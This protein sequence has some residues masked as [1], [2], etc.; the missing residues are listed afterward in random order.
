MRKEM[1]FILKWIWLVPLL[2]WIILTL[3]NPVVAIT[4]PEPEIIDTTGTEE[5]S[6]N[7]YLGIVAID[8]DYYNSS[9]TVIFGDDVGKIIWE[10]GAMRFEGNAEESAKIFFDY[11]LKPMIDGYIKEQL[12]K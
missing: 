9:N 11:F 5:E 10:D 8:S 3:L 2:I 6:D 7:D 4:E 12:H 1:K